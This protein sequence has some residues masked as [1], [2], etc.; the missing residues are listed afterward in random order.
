MEPAL[1]T[2]VS[3]VFAKYNFSKEDAE[4]ITEVLNGIDDRKRN[5]FEQKMDTLVTQSDKAD[6]IR[7][8]REDKA[9]LIGLMQKDK[10]ELIGLMQKDKIELIDRINNVSKQIYIVGLIQF[11]AIIASVLAIVN[12]ML[13]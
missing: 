6:I 13:K 8:M 4:F 12:F 2:K 1:K 7:S 3:E 9:E 5:E 10:A 11:L